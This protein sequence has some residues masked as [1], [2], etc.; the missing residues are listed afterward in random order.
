MGTSKQKGFIL[1]TTVWM[2]AILAILA[3]IFHGYVQNQVTVA[4][5]I[6]LRVQADLDIDAT[7][8][9]LRYLL[10]TRRTT[11]AG[12]TVL[13]EHQ[14][15]VITDEG[16]ADISPVGS[17]IKL[18]DSVYGGIG[19]TWFQLQD[20]AGLLGLNSPGAEAFF[21][22]LLR[23]RVSSQVARELSGALADY[24][25]GNSQ[26]RFN[27]AER[28]QYEAAN[29]PGPTNWFLRTDREI[30]DVLGWG[31]YLA[32]TGLAAALAPTYAN[33]LNVNTAPTPLLALL[34]SLDEEQVQRV[35]QARNAYPFRS[36]D[37]VADAANTFPRWEENR[38]RFYSSDQLRVTLGCA[39]CGFVR[40][41]SIELTPDGYFGPWLTDYIYQR[42]L[43]KG[44]TTNVQSAATVAGDL[45]KDALP[46]KG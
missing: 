14:L 20:Q 39:E 32:E 1:A 33:V 35:V 9:T 16:V 3:G 12:L 17:E 36:L 30:S 26:R 21:F 10:G 42:P 44:Q 37:G 34:L 41:E 22:E 2:I 29:L 5:A 38:F 18:D 23:N 28:P 31:G 15:N 4:R 24:I 8:V 11:L 43:P 40:V 7:A 19:K 13:P 46:T 45:F 27:G 25:D 6:K